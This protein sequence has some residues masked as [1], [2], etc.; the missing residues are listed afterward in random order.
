MILSCTISRALLGLPDLELNASPYRVVSLSPGGQDWDRQVAKSPYLDGEV[1][2]QRTRT[3]PEVELT[4][5]VTEATEAALMASYGVLVDAFNQDEFV[6]TLTIDGAVRSWYGEAADRRNDFQKEL[7]H[8]R[9]QQVT[10]RF[11]R[12]PGGLGVI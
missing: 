2:T 9:M 6:F 8:A 3:S 5:R 10:F 11:K 12:R 7:V 1:T 4:E